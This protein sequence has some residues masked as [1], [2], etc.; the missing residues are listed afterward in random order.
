[1]RCNMHVSEDLLASFLILPVDLKVPYYTNFKIFIYNSRLQWS[2]CSQPPAK[3][4]QNKHLMEGVVMNLGEGG[5]VYR[6]ETHVI[7]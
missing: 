5:L 4:G 7:I 1:M 2:S 3:R 6:L